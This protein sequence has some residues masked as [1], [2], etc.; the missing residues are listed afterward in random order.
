MSMSIQ[1]I[2]IAVHENARVKGFHPT[3]ETLGQYISQTT[4][5]LHGEVS[6]FWEAYR[7]GELDAMCDKAE[8][9]LTCAEEELADII[10]R[11][12]D[13]AQRLGIDIE[14]AI[15]AK[16]AYNT[17]REFRHGGKLA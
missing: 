13:T 4:A 7:K 14:R 10:I 3:N 15:L 6:E 9:G 11:A 2:A 1:E 16:H 8:T 12:L 17:R 5:N